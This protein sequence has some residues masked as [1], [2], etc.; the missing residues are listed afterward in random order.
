[1]TLAEKLSQVTWGG[2]GYS[3]YDGQAFIGTALAIGLA[4]TAAAGSVGSAAIASHGAG[5]AAK[6]Q[7]DAANQSAQLQ[8]QDATAALAEQRRQYD[9]NQGNISPF[10]RIGQS[11]AANY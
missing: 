6:A 10:L 1:M 3:N 4:A 5:K 7:T 2:E 9:I 8:H 11:A